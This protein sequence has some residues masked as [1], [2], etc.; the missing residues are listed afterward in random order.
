MGPFK[1]Q[2]VNSSNTLNTIFAYCHASVNL[3][4]VVVLYLEDGNV[5]RPV[6]KNETTTMFFVKTHFLV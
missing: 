1:I 4:N 3:D 6:L 2:Y 5:Y